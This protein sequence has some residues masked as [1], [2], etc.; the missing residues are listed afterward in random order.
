[1]HG[2]NRSSCQQAHKTHIWYL[3]P[4]PRRLGVVRS[5]ALWRHWQYTGSAEGRQRPR[6]P[7]AATVLGLLLSASCRSCPA[8]H[9]AAPSDGGCGGCGGGGEQRRAGRGS[10]LT[11]HTALPAAAQRPESQPSRAQQAS[12]DRSHDEATKV[13]GSQQ[14]HACSRQ[15]ALGCAPAAMPRWHTR[16]HSYY[17]M[18]M[19]SIGS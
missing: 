2:G 10:E 16:S 14:R 7:S 9:P 3:T 1:M 19:G 4:L 5:T 13:E 12:K 15:Q 17:Y 18:Y 6:G 8:V 11:P